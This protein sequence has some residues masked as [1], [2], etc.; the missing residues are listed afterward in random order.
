[1][2]RLIDVD[3]LIT[4]LDELAESYVD[5]NYNNFTRDMHNIYRQQGVDVAIEL[6]KMQE[7]IDPVKHGHWEYCGYCANLPIAYCTACHEYALYND[8]TSI[9]YS[10]YCPYCGARMDGDDK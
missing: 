1:M 7:P 6:V 5:N 4:E 10:K 8:D 3:N 9:A 2:T